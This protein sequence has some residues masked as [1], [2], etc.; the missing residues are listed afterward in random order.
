MKRVAVLLLV[1]ACGGGSGGAVATG[2][3]KADYLK[4]AEV[5]CTKTNTEQK[6]LKTPT[7]VEELAPYVARIV[8]IAD[9]ATTS[10]QALTPPSG[11]VAALTQKV[12]TPLREQLVAGH[13]YADQVA[14]AAKAKDNKALVTLL[15]NP[16]T[17]TKA[18]L[19]WMKDYGFKECV[20]AA[21]TS[22]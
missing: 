19:R 2:V 9:E 14:V 7:A 12:F 6:A 5:I 4:A 22:G 15:S 18:D 21:D 10:L 16:P 11:D 8:A 20:D 1:A 13:A 17:K 3:S